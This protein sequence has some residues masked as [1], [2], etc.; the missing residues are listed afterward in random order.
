[1]NL[2]FLVGVVLVPTNDEY[3]ETIGVLRIALIIDFGR[4]QSSHL[5]ELIM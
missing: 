1:M 3:Y 2:E 4:V 5:I